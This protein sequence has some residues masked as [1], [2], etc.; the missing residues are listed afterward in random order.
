MTDSQS[1]PPQ[2]DYAV[3]PSWP[4][5][6]T[7]DYS[8]VSHGRPGILTAVGVISIVLGSLGLLRS[9]SQ[10]VS[11]AG[12]L[13]ISQMAFPAGATAPGGGMTPA[14]AISAT[15][16]AVIAAALSAAQPLSTADQARIASAIQS[17]DIPLA[18]PPA[19]QAW[20]AEHVAAQVN[21]TSAINSAVTYTLAGGSIQIDP[22]TIN[23]VSSSAS[24]TGMSTTTIS[25]TGGTTTFGMANNPFAGISIALVVA[26]TLVE[27]VN[28]ALAALLLTAGIATLR[29]SMRS[30]R[31]HRW[32]AWLKF[33][34]VALSTAV[35]IWMA[36]AFFESVGMTVTQTPGG[37]GNATAVATPAFGSMGWLMVIPSIGAAVLAC[38][39]PVA[40]LIVFG[41]GTARAYYAHPGIERN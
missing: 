35:G 33:P 9:L 27:L 2:A 30:P 4:A 24:G 13:L 6:P 23:I 39:Y 36:F 20:T 25:A 34:A 26:G 8:N 17:A 11:F 5:R 7:L 15:D 41:T 12:M 14:G 32:W 3:Q 31:L 21:A 10:M 40:V 22:A 29:G 37:P 28:L 18:P 19:G 38:I 1:P 16:A